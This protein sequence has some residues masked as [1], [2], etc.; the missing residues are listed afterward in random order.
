MT[1]AAMIG[2]R[3]ADADGSGQERPVDMTGQPEL[4]Q[5]TVRQI[6]QVLRRHR[7]LIAILVGTSVLVTLV[8]QL[9][10]TPI[11]EAGAI[12]Q[13]ELNDSAGANQA[14]IAARNQQRVANEARTMRSRAL[15]ERVVRDLRLI[16]NPAF[17]GDQVVAASKKSE[18]AIDQASLKIQDMT[19]IISS[20][21][22]DF[23]DVVVTSPDPE[24][25]TRIANQYVR[26]LQGQRLSRRNNRRGEMYA[27]LSQETDRLAK[28]VE[29]ADNR[30]A[31]FRRANAMLVGAGGAEDLQ[32][33][34]RIATEAASASG[35]Q[36]AMA[37]RSA[38]ISR[39]AN[40]RTTAG[41]SS[42]LL[43]QQQRE[44][45]T[46]LRERARM[47]AT[48]GAGHPDMITLGAQMSELSR[49]ME[50]EQRSVISAT[51][52]TAAADAA[53]ETQLA[54]SE[55]ASAAARAARL[56]GQLNTMTSKAYANTTHAVELSALERRAEI[57]RQ[58]YLATAQRAQEVK[59]ELASTGVNSTLV[60]GAVIPTD[61][62]YPTPKRAVASAFGGSLMLALL[63]VFAIEM[64][65]N[66]LRTGDQVR[67][68]FGLPTFGMF[69]DI[70]GRAD[71]SIEESPVLREPQ[72]LFAE[73]ARSLH[74]EV[75]QLAARDG[76][77]TVLITSP[78]PGDGKSTVA[79]S[80]V[81]AASAMGRRAVV[82]DLDL[83]RPG[84]LQEIQQR[85]DGPDL[86]DFLTGAVDAQKMLVSPERPRDPRQIITYKPVVLSTREPVR[87]PASLIRVGKIRMLFDDLRER[88]DLI[89]INAPAALAVRDARTLTDVADS[90]LVVLRWGH[91]TIEQARATLQ[92]LQHQVAGVVFNQVD[93]AE[94][95]RRGY[96]DS[97]QFYVDA[98]AYYSGD[99]P[100][101]R[102]FADRIRNMFG[103]RAYG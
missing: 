73:V 58:V 32:Q 46:L 17:M 59:A 101:P 19:K 102:R 7:L 94:H 10:A 67:R 77:Q 81:A 24:L 76:P 35:M 22:S 72:S 100:R 61:P 98:A 69:P 53:R 38:G 51:Q 68:L 85:L 12:V 33:I 65:D 64:F 62:T 57:A 47:S 18:K 11:Y 83:R 99:I 4:Q 31:E 34:N 92:L 23:I 103:K 80:L 9:I 97:V 2:D 48:L 3:R 6:W 15:A 95:A 96:G 52:A 54:Q 43:Q 26:S 78:L 82:V 28:A 86:V 70:A 13:V 79:L 45:D 84:V 20:P 29:D 56:S 44:Y 36:A 74:A 16:N 21:D 49:N 91:T 30:V 8:T 89:V 71:M 41:A 88:F 60:S 93:Y 66:K 90:T 25:A 50:A 5:L 37:A 63:L 39:A 75:A 42:P 55:A 40:M 27:A 87:D 14:E 1:Y